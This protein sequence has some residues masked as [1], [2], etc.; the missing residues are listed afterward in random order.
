[1]SIV[2]EEKVLKRGIVELISEYNFLCDVVD[3][4]YIIGKL[5]KKKCKEY[6]KNVEDKN[7]LEKILEILGIVEKEFETGI[8]VNDVEISK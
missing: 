6:L 3:N 1:M 2:V 5:D 7:R 8:G 4:E